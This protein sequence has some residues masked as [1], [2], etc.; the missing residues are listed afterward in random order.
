[1][2]YNLTDYSARVLDHYEYPRNAGDLEDPDAVATVENP[3]CGDTVRL[4]LRVTGGRI[5]DV[6]FKASGCAAAI[7]AS[8]AA[9]ELILGRSLEEAADVGRD[10]VTEA[11]GG[12]PP[13]K[14][15]CSI[16]AEQA[17]RTVVASFKNR[18][19]LRGITNEGSSVT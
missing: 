4:A 6:R 1:M 10:Q 14:V 7:A 13:S 16:L 3:A 15:H 19:A 8:S 11:L 17:V 9:T 2:A 18:P 5:S 12:L